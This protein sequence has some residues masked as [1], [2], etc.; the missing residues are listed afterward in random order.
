MSFLDSMFNKDDNSSSK[1]E[2]IIDRKGRVEDV[3]TGVVTPAQG[4]EPVQPSSQNEIDLNNYTES[5]SP[6]LGT[7]P[8]VLEQ[9]DNTQNVFVASEKNPPA[10]TTP[11]TPETTERVV[12]Q[13][14]GENPDNLKKKFN[15]LE[16]GMNDEDAQRYNKFQDT[17]KKERVVKQYYGENPDNLKKKFNSLEEA[18]NDEDTERY[19]K[20]Q[21]TGKKERVV[22][23]YYGENPDNLKKKFNSLEEG[24]NDKDAERY[25][26]FQDTG[27]DQGVSN[28]ITS[29]STWA[30][31]GEEKRRR[32]ALH[33]E[34]IDR[35]NKLNEDFKDIKTVSNT[36]KSFFAERAQAEELKN[37]HTEIGQL[38][39]EL[40]LLREELERLTNPPIEPEVTPTEPEV[41]PTE[42]EV[43]P[44]EPEVTPTE[45]EVTPTE[46]ELTSESTIIDGVYRDVTPEENLRE[47]LLQEREDKKERDIKRALLIGGAVSGVTTGILVSSSAALPIGATLIGINALAYGTDFALG[48]YVQRRLTDRISNETDQDR[49]EKLQQRLEKINRIR[50]GIKK[51]VKPFVSAAGIGFLV[52]AGIKYATQS[53]FD[54][55]ANVGQ[56]TVQNPIENPSSTPNNA[57]PINN[58]P[59]IPSTTPTQPPVEAL[60]ENVITSNGRVNLPG[61]AWDGNLAGEAVGNLPGE[62]LNHSN[63]IGGIHEMAPHLAEEA[64]KQ[65]GV[66]RDML[67]Q[68]LGTDGTHRLLNGF[69]DAINRG[70]TNPSLTEVLSNIGGEGAQNLLEIIQ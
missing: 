32:E 57:N 2:I 14:Y 1:N 30:K 47:Q 56:E 31:E 22:K 63:Y 23:Q 65:A 45:P 4:N 27:E 29:D 24:M 66:T 5:V 41:T 62:V 10:Q 3:D 33:K 54:K 52:S 46:P 60:T 40:A 68:N 11:E 69:V 19:N 70:V 35:N 58:N 37:L 61:S 26:K 43:T 44:T 36:G 17:G 16:E 9:G 15:S 20:F 7:V 39:E 49:K 42:P 64:L 13:Y 8:Q 48:R 6:P 25:N 21:D 53:I 28:T 51:Y 67:L 34:E 18:M 38:R 59:N 12:K 55:P 50:I